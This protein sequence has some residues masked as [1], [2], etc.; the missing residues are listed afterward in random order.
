MIA[1][2]INYV[3]ASLALVVTHPVSSIYL[4]LSIVHLIA[5]HCYLRHQ[6]GRGLAVC[7]G[8]ASVLYA[9][10]AGLHGLAH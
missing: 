1:I 5:M 2:V 4:G 6:D 7:A 8:L 9:L 10:L 3:V